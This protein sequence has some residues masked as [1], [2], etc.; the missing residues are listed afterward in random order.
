M[1]DFAAARRELGLP[2]TG[3]SPDELAAGLRALAGLR[4]ALDACEA[5]VL[6]EFAVSGAWKRDGAVDAAAWLRDQ[7]R[8]SARDAAGRVAAAEVL[9]NL[10]R[11]VSA[12]ADGEITAEHATA[13]ARAA[14]RSPAIAG[15]EASL[16]AHAA[17]QS[18][19]GFGRTLRRLEQVVSADSGA[20]QALRQHQR[21]SVTATAIDDGMTLLQARLDPIAA[22]SVV[23]RLDRIAEEL[24]RTDSGGARAVEWHVRRADALVEMARRAGAVDP[25]AMQ[26]PEP[27]IVAVIDHRYLLDQLASA[28]AGVCQLDNGNPIP[29]ATARRLACSA[30]IL[31]AVLGGASVPLDWGRTR[32]L[33]SA[34]QRQALLVRDGGCVFPGCDR[35]HT[36]CDAH[37]LT[38]YP[39]G[40]T[41]LDNL[42]SLCDAHHHLVHEG[43][44]TL[45]RLPDGAWTAR[46]PHGTQHH[47][48]A[49][50][51]SPDPPAPPT[52]HHQLPLGA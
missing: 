7:T 41:N 46:S 23:G 2:V 10:P 28:G 44:W 6:A 37:H 33:A 3:R 39:N 15:H 50:T 51:T 48:P 38:P 16:L 43:R 25:D 11:T 45:Q 13:I 52:N 24:W 4:S 9:S 42:A 14:Q 5:R 40:P 21:R 49:R 12:L 22:A 47:R 31:P 17:G 26:R 36:W 34:T 20:G 19:D 8:V 32:R 27:T 29:P 35:P 30:G 1:F 18:V